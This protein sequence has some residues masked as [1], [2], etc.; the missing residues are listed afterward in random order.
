[1]SPTSIKRI[2]ISTSNK[3][4]DKPILEEAKHI[5]IDS[6]AGDED[7]VLDRFYKTAKKY[8]SDILIRITGDCPLIDPEI[9]DLNIKKFLEW[10][11]I[12][13]KIHEVII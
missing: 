4:I 13:F 11:N 6:F 12:I 10:R 9:V 5:S 1:M 3:D 7:D 2:I 8:K